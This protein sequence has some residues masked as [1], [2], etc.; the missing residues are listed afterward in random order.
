M[1][2]ENSLVW[3]SA[4]EIGTSMYWQEE[5]EL[6]RLHL[7]PESQLLWEMLYNAVP[8]DDDQVLSDS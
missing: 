8:C 2:R 6:Y 1:G 3:S 7:H 4:L 5:S